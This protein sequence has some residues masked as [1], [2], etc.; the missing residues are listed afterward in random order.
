MTFFWLGVGGHDHF[1]AGCGRV[2]VGMTFSW[3]GVGGCG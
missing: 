2:W 3:L 1:L